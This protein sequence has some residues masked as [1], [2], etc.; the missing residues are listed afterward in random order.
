MR[1]LTSDDLAELER[2]ASALCADGWADF[3]TFQRLFSDWGRLAAEVGNY[4]AT[5]DD[6]TNDLSSRKGLQLIH[7]CCSRVVAAGLAE[8][9]RPVDAKFIEGT[10]ADD[11]GVLGRFSRV[12]EDSGWWLRRIPKT[13]PLRTYL[14]DARA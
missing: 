12:D 3:V 2:C 6:Y 8:H 4:T 7:Q 1:A 5:V 14:D 10:D 13:G 11:S 9:L